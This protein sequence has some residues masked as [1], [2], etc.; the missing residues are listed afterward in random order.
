MTK[1]FKIYSWIDQEMK[2]DNWYKVES[3]EQKRIILEIMATGLIP[4]CEFN[5]T[6]SEFR[7]SRFAFNLIMLENNFKT[8]QTY[9]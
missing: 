2:F 9:R 7:K 5:S 4:D 8:F 6:Y 1:L 3:E